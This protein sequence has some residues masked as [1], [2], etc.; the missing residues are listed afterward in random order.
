MQAGA[1]VLD[2]PGLLA[3]A[4]SSP[5]E[6]LEVFVDA[7]HLDSADLAASMALLADAGVPVRSVA[8]GVLQRVADPVHP[9]PVLSVVRRPAA[10]LDCLDGPQAL[11]LVLAELADPGNVGTLLRV[12][13]AAGAGAVVAA[14]SVADPF[15]PKALRASAGSALRVP[16]VEV[17]VVS[18]AVDEL[19]ARGYVLV[20]AASGATP[21]DLAAVD[22]PV[23]LLLG[24]EAHG[25]PDDIA[26]AVD[27]WVGIPMHG[28]VESLNVAVAGAVV[29]FEV[30]R[31]GRT[32]KS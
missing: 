9:R 28:R 29:S 27:E 16:V 11:V 24:S 19:G 3:E 7:E 13:E 14:G 22:P 26:R 15:G 5:V 8:P 2:G 6:L 18:T 23:G 12:A 4:L 30:A 21:Y 20:G 31:R 25:L 1:I 10:G 32:A 17:P